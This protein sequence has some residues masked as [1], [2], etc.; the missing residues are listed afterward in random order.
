MAL[1]LPRSLELAV[2]L[3]AVLKS[4][5]GYVPVDP[6]LPADRVR[7]LL[8]DA[9]PVLLFT[10][11]AATSGLPLCRPVPRGVPGLGWG[12]VF[13]ASVSFDIGATALYGALVPGGC[14]RVAAWDALD[15]QRL[16]G[17]RR[18]GS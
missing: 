16:G 4:G 5:A 10:H 11:P 6:D 1:A 17:A 7:Y 8:A 9:G 3:L 15:E 2:A 18:P 12:T 13:H 14:V